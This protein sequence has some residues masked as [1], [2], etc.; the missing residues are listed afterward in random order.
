MLETA[1]LYHCLNALIKQYVKIYLIKEIKETYFRTNSRNNKQI[2]T[3][4]QLFWCG[5]TK[6]NFVIQ[7]ISFD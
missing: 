4:T 1:Y 2:V 7:Y 5:Q 3:L 6:F